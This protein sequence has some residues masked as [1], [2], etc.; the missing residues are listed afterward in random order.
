LDEGRTFPA[1]TD[2]RVTSTQALLRHPRGTVQ[3][4]LPRPVRHFVDRFD[5]AGDY[6]DLATNLPPPRPLPGTELRVGLHA[7]QHAVVG[8]E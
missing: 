2:L 8:E 7:V 1:A 4:W 3:V 6:A 5:L